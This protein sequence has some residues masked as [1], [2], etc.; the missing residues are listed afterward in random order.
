[1]QALNPWVL[2]TEATAAAATNG[3]RFE[4]GCARQ[5][6]QQGGELWQHQQQQQ[7][8]SQAE[9]PQQSVPRQQ[10]QRHPHHMYSWKPA[11][12]YSCDFSRVQ[13]AWTASPSAAAAAPSGGDGYAGAA[14]GTNG[15]TQTDGG[16]SDA[17][18][19]GSAGS[20][21]GAGGETGGRSAA[22]FGTKV[23]QAAIWAHQH[24]KSCKD[25]RFL[26]HTPQVRHRSCAQRW[27]WMCL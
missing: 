15:S 23:A 10:Q 26:L 24:P 9:A 6:A 20:G 25:Q 8:A 11:D 2:S 27:K 4:T 5:L 14:D 18:S 22:L 19:T 21:G 12:P 16:G 3:I 13:G 7:G 1:M 17:E